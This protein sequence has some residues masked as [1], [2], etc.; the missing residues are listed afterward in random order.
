ML[1][2]DNIQRQ[3]Q[4]N[5]AAKQQIG[6]AAAALLVTGQHVALSA[7]TTV[8]E[9]ARGLRGRTGLRVVT[10]ALNI[11]YELGREP[12]IK[13]LCTGGEVDSDYATLTGPVA[14][15]TLRAHFFDI[16]VV[17][18][19]GV[20]ANAGLTVN[21]PLNA[22]TLEQMISQSSRIIVVADQTKLGRVCFARLAPLDSVDVLVTEIAPA[23]ALQTALNSAN[24]EIVLAM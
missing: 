4:S 14:E 17:G 13:V 5:L 20:D 2:S 21:S 3:A 12:G 19:S 24:V 6:R 23:P 18:V 1:H 10:N 16:A 7:G 15:R 8:T 9:V 22:V 11:A